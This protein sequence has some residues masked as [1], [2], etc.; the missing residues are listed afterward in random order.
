MN[1]ASWDVPIYDEDVLDY[2]TS[3]LDSRGSTPADS[4]QRQTLK[5]DLPLLQLSDWSE[6]QA[7]DEFPP[8]CIYWM[9][10]PAK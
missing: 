9:E 6:D 3:R 10:T 4:S 2:R 8:T 7:Y 1:N 5:P